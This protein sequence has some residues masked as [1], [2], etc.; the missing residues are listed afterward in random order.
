MDSYKFI[1]GIYV[2]FVTFTVVDWLPIFINPEPLN[3]IT[4]SLNFCIN[5]RSLRVYAYVIMPNH[6]HLVVFDAKFD[7]ARLQKTLAKFRKFTGHKL[8]DYVDN[9]LA[10]SISSVIRNNSM[11]DRSRVVW[12]PGWHA[13]GLASEAFVNQKVEYI[14]QNPVSKGYVQVPE[15]WRFSSAGFWI[16]GEAGDIPISMVIEEEE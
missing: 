2:Y 9:N 15:H 1:E 7:N 11:K 14:H 8:A 3:I 5:E 6:L 13:E 12:I 16:N 10:T 4:D